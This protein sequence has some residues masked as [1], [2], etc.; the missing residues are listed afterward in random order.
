[1]LSNTVRLRRL[2]LR[3]A[4]AF[5]Q[6]RVELFVIAKTTMAYGIKVLPPHD[7]LRELRDERVSKLQ[8]RFPEFNSTHSDLLHG[9]CVT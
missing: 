2:S 7:V 9:G 3:R 6:R 8:C 5:A 1:M 4:I